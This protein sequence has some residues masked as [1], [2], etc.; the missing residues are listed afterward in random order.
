MCG[1]GAWRGH[2]RWRVTGKDAAEV[3][4][5]VG[6]FGPESHANVT[7]GLQER[8][9]GGVIVS[10]AGQAHAMARWRAEE[11]SGAGGG[12]EVASVRMEQSKSY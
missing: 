2:R 10:S 4:T 12:G 6:C 3:H 7:P 8:D 9:S 1:A 11:R 5:V